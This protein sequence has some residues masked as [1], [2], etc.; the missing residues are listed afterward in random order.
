MNTTTMIVILLFAGKLGRLWQHVGDVQT[1][2]LAQ[3]KPPQKLR[4]RKLRATYSRAALRDALKW[5]A[6]HSPAQPSLKVDVQVGINPWHAH[7]AS[8]K[9]KSEQQPSCIA[10]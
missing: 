8:A 3:T 6:A 7:Q 9:G 4:G 2:C 10:C 1:F 5:A